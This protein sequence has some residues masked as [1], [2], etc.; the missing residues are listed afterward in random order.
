ME[1]CEEFGLHF[2]YQWG[3]FSEKRFHSAESP[4]D[5]DGTL[6]QLNLTREATLPDVYFVSLCVGVNSKLVCIWVLVCLIFIFF[7][8]LHTDM[9]RNI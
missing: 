9:G 6:R 8:L 2:N 3:T 4:S 1:G 5:D 7:F